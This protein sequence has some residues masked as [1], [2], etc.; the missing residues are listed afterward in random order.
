ML[1][2]Q[3]SGATKAVPGSDYKLLLFGGTGA[4]G[5][6]LRSAYVTAGWTVTATSRREAPHVVA[7]DPFGAAVDWLALDRRGPFQ[8]VTWAQGANH[9]DTVYDVDVDKHMAL[10]QANCLFNIATLKGLLE[11]K[12]LVCP[13]RLVVV[14]S[15]W[16][17]L[18]RQNKLSYCVS[19]AALQGFVTSAAAD[20]AKDGHLVNAILP[21]VLD[22]PMTHKNL[23]PEQIQVFKGATKFDRLP[24]LSDVT[25]LA[26]FLSSPQ[27][28]GIT[29][30][31]IEADLGFS[32]V[33]LV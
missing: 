19:K 4:I 5:Q 8:A 16:Q 27:N 11:R 21:G 1:N 2:H 28:T 25:N 6:A 20:L 13:A 24:A 7:F 33:R 9:N 17:N 26:V 3:S 15:I 30:Q 31:F 23:A 22:T 18:A 10:Y 29:G 12:L 14:S 32:H